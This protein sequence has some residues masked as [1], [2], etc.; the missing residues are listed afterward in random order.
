[1]R[2][3]Q[4][5]DVIAELI[6]RRPECGS[7]GGSTAKIESARDCNRRVL[8]NVGIGIDADIRWGKELRSRAVHAHAAYRQAKRI[9]DACT[10]EIRVAERERLRQV[11]EAFA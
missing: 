6:E 10:R 9:D 3:A 4:D 7:R 8:G 11:V 2:S 5:A 1:M